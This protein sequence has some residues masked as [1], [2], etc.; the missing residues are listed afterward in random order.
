MRIADLLKESPTTFSFEFFPPKDE[1]A[2]DLLLARAE[3][4]AK[5]RP[6]F[7]SV[8]YGAGGT[9]RNRTRDVVVQLQD[10]VGLSTAAHLTCVGHSRAELME[11]LETYRQRGVENI[12]ALRGDAATILVSPSRAIPKATRKRPTASAISTISS[13]RSTQAP[14]R[15]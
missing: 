15:L 3:Q 10:K 1:S 13:E 12:V 8:T 9:T 5:L 7:V 2:V 6:T 4:L 14:T 11:I